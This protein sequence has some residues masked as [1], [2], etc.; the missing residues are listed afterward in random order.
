MFNLASGQYAPY[1]VGY[2]FD[3]NTELQVLARLELSSRQTVALSS[4]QVRN[5][6]SAHYDVA[7]L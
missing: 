4:S 5:L 3:G 6:G 1:Q 7:Q 2:S